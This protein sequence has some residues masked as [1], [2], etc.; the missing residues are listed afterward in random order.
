MKYLI[1]K[2]NDKINNICFNVLHLFNVI[3]DITFFHIT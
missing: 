1:S 2:S 3:H